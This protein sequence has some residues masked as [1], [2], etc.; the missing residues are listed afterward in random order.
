MKSVSIVNQFVFV[1]WISAFRKKFAKKEK[2]QKK[3]AI[4]LI[5]HYYIDEDNTH[6]FI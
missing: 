1:K 4:S 6:L 5:K 2:N 3:P